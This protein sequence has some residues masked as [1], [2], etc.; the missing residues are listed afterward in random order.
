MTNPFALRD[1]DRRAIWEILMRRDAAAFIANDWSMTEPDFDREGFCA[2]DACHSA[3][4]DDW[5]LRYASLNAYRDEWLRQR[6]E[7]SVDDCVNDPEQELLA[8]MS[9]SDIEI[10]ADRA[11]AHK[12]FNGV[13]RLRKQADIEL[14]WKTLYQLRKVDG[15]WKITG[16][17]GYL[18]N[19]DADIESASHRQ[20]LKT[21][22]FNA[23]QHVTAGPYSPVLQVACG[24]LVIISGQAAI[25]H[26]GNVIGDDIESQTALTLDNCEMQL[27]SAGASLDDVFKVN[28]YMQDLNE[29]GR[30]NTI[31]AQRMPHPLPVRTAVQAGLLMT[32]KVEIEMWAMLPE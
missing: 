30:F 15:D 5:K 18:P 1:T 7:F 9:L 28:V 16:F 20:T 2:V 4:P 8:A 10:H 3:N 27:R 11:I 22:P 24:E 14:C 31:Y 19:T 13:I 23:A 12:T 17:V 32:L 21:I 26:A 25:D 29:W 6:A